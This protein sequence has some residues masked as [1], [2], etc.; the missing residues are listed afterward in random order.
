MAYATTNRYNEVIYSQDTKNKLK[1]LFNN[2][3]LE[4]ADIYC[5][6]L[7]IN[8][9]IIPNG[10]S[11]FSLGNFVSKEATLILHNIDLD[12]IQDEV[13]ISI[14]TLVDKENDVYE[15]VPIGIFNIQDTPTTDKNKTTISLR[16]K[17]TNFD[18]YYNAE[19]L[20]DL[21][22]GKAT[23]RQ[24]LDDICNQAGVENGVSEFLGEDGY[25]SFY[26]NTL[27]ARQF[28][29]YLAEQAGGIPI[30]N[31][32]G[33]LEFIYLKNLETQEIP[34]NI[35]ES[36]QNGEEFEI[37]KVVYESGIIKYEAG[38]NAKDTLYIDS[39]NPYITD[40]SI[41]KIIN[42]NEIEIFD[43]K[44]KSDIN[45]GYDFIYFKK[46]GIC[47]QEG[48]STPSLPIEIKTIKDNLIIEN[49]N[50]ENSL[51]NESLTTII[52][53]QGNELNSI[54]DI[55]DELIIENNNTKIIKK[56]GKLVLNGTENW[57]KTGTRF[58]LELP[59]YS[60]GV[61]LT[62]CSHFINVASWQIHTGTNN[63]I[64]L[65]KDGGWN[66]VRLSIN[67]NRF[68]T[69]SDFKNWLQSN[70][71][72]VYYELN[73][74]KEIDLGNANISTFAGYNR[75]NTPNQYNLESNIE[76]KYVS[77]QR[78]IDKI[79]EKVV[80][81]KINSFKTGKIL[82]N[83]AIDPYDLISINEI[84]KNIL[85][86]N[87]Q[88]GGINF[89][90]SGAE[91]ANNTR[92]RTDFIPIK[93]NTNYT[94]SNNDDRIYQFGLGY[95]DENKE[96]LSNN[97][98]YSGGWVD[99]N[100]TFT[101]PQNAKYVRIIFKNY[102]NDSNIDPTIKYIT[103]LEQGSI[104]TYYV[105]Y[106]NE[107]YKTLATQTLIYN[108]NLIAN[109]DTQIKM[110]N[111]ISNV[112]YNSEATFRRFAKSNIDNLNTE[113][114]NVVVNQNETTEKIS[115]VVQ[116]VNNIQNTFQITGGNNLIK[117]SQGLLGDDVWDYSDNGEYEVGFD[118]S[119]IGKTISNA[120]LGI[121]NGKMT[122]LNNNINNLVIGRQYTLSYK[123]TNQPNTTSKIKLIGNN[124]VYQEEF[125]TPLEM[126]EKTF[127][128]IAETSSY[129]LE[130]ES[131]TVLNGFTYIY[132]LMLNKG[133]ALSW[134]VASGE[135][136]GTILKMSQLGL[137]IVSTG[138]EIATLMTAQGF[139]IRRYSNGNLYEIVTEFTKDGILTTKIECT[140][141]N[142]NSFDFKVINYSGRDTLV[143]YKKE[144]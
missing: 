44:N 99:F 8:S 91:V 139:Q 105:P 76:I 53:L 89:G 114:K 35:V 33:V 21:N 22:G 117:D 138:S 132:D 81:F 90:S 36:Y 50:N 43:N 122:T 119:L 2:V 46:D 120:K 25:T 38:T 83:P 94:I 4:N 41:N 24:I 61:K 112:S 121:R 9:R 39:S 125:N 69:A 49:F 51:E 68:S 103:Q 92:I 59:N 79:L 28:I 86:D 14:G 106:K 66:N 96:Y 136:V 108:G 98:Y 116:T 74:T 75:I 104:A 55:K 85:N 95:Y 101:T 3:E 123:I 15:Y 56:I 10:N 27:T 100:K 80:D 30:I 17:S 141:V 126:V 115:E 60:N 135:I 65:Y 109:Y 58:Y 16:D 131:S 12:I 47:L 77:E 118:S 63:S 93:P 34:L 140:E 6:K 107:T 67:D 70:N 144:S 20:I 54:N 29:S 130:I 32:N 124:V 18:F 48:T 111:K 134:E 23:K 127:S 71:V 110:E 129:T 13:N 88:K 133:D 84:S 102:N 73:E 40:D 19:P 11:N 97:K 143:I 1:I 72:T 37:S 26:D 78:Q 64:I 31:R 57:Q 128:F 82:G 142:V 42:G 52:N 7:T 45:E 5:E 87:L 62:L 113:I 137:Q